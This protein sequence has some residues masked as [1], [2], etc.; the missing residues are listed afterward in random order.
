ML[1]RAIIRGCSVCPSVSCTRDSR[2][3]SS[4]YRNT[5]HIVR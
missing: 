5:F 1:E 4:R 2:L 3:N